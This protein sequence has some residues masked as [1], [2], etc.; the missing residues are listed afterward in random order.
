MLL[1]GND[2]QQW[3]NQV[4]WLDAACDC[5]KT[6]VLASTNA[7]VDND[8]PDV[9]VKYLLTLIHKENAQFKKIEYNSEPPCFHA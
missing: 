6:V 8:S 1:K 4:L 5:I 7:A 2:N 3:Q 9:Q